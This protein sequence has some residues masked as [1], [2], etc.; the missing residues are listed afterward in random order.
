MNKI[1]NNIPN[2]IKQPSQCCIHCGKTY[3]KRINLDRH[4]VLCELLYLSK[5]SS[6]NSYM[7]EEEKIPSQ[8][9]MFHMLLELGEKFSRLEGKMEEINKWVIK[10]KKK[11]NVL[12][13][14]NNNLK[15]N[16]TFD[17][18]LDKIIV[19]EKDILNLFDYSF[20]DVLNIIF[21]NN[22][23]QFNE[24][25]NPI[26]AFIQKTNVFYIYDNDCIWKELS[27]EILIKFLNKIHMKIIKCFYDWKKTKINEIKIDDN[28]ATRCNKSS[29]KLM[30]IEFKQESILN[31][32]ISQ[33][34]SK[35]KTDMKALIEYE[36][37]F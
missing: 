29:V 36:F 28:F 4:I 2:K 30:S 26:F 1:T 34:Y 17:Q 8:K 15:P 6:I 27:R 32:I 10:K 12:D 18:V 3:K 16:I 11:I 37:E 5:K 31:K 23:Y 33:M 21:S 20:Y 35:M 14:L 22:I 13:W 9:K 7:E 19:C 24:N 25:E